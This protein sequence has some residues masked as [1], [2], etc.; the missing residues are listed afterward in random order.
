MN[1]KHVT[2]VFRPDFLQRLWGC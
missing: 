2:P 1:D